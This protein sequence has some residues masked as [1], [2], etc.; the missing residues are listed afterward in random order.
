MRQYCPARASQRYRPS[1]TNLVSRSS[2]FLCSQAR[3]SS[4]LVST[5]RARRRSSFGGIGGF[6][7]RKLVKPTKVLCSWPPY[8]GGFG[9]VL[10]SQTKPHVGTAAA[11]VPGEPDAA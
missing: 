11:G 10:A 7:V 2:C 5:N 1:S 4:I 6:L 8:Q 3:I 9:H